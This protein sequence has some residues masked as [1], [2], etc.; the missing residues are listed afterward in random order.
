[1][2]SDLALHREDV[3][4]MVEI[5]VPPERSIVELAVGLYR[6]LGIDVEIADRSIRIAVGAVLARPVQA[7]LG[8]YTGI[9]AHNA[10]DDRA[11]LRG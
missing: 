9:P 7:I 1:M 5:E 3:L 11:A 4:R 10:W 6:D 8:R 2:A